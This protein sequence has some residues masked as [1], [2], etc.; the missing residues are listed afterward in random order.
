TPVTT[1]V[2]ANDTFEG[3]PVVTAVTQGTNGTVSI[4]ADN[5]ITYT[6]DVDFNGTDS[7]SYTVTSGGV[8]ETATVNVAVAPVVDI[9]DDIVTTDEDTAVTTDVLSND[10]FEGAPVVTA[11]TQAANGTVTINADNT[12]TYTPNHNYFGTDSYT[13]TVTSGGVTE[14]AVV[15]VTVNYVSDAVADEISTDEDTAVTTD[16]LANDTFEGAAAVTSV[17]QGANGAV[18]INAD[19]MVTYTPDADF[20]G[21]DSYS[22]TVTSGGVTETTTVSVTVN[23]V[24]DITDDSASTDEDTS[25]T[26]A[27]LSND[28]FEGTATV[29]AVTQGANGSVT[30]NADSTVTYTPDADFNGTDSYS[31]TVTSGGVTETATV[32]VTIN[33]VAD[34]A[35]DSATTVEDTTVTTD[36][37]AN[38]GFTGTPVV[39][40]VTQGANGTVTIN[41]DNTVSYTPNPDYYGSDSYSYTVT[42]GGVTETISVDVS[43]QPVADIVQDVVT[44]AEDKSVVSQLLGND[45]FA[46]SATVTSVTQGMNGTVHVN[47]DN[48][49]T[50]T[51]HPDFNGADQYSYTVTSGGFMETAT[52]DVTVT[53]VKDIMADA[54]VIDESSVITMNLLEND[55]F[56]GSPVIL[57][58]TQ[59]LNGSVVVN[60]DGTVTYTP[61]VGFIDTDTYSYTVSSG[62][63]LETAVVTVSVVPAANTSSP[64][65]P[66]VIEDEGLPVDGP[67]GIDIPVADKLELPV[68]E[69]IP[70][71]LSG[72]GDSLDNI[73]DG[74][75]SAADDD[76]I[77]LDENNEVVS[78]LK[79]RNNSGYIYFDADFYKQAHLLKSSGADYRVIDADELTGSGSFEFGKEELRQF[80]GEDGFTLALAEMDKAFDLEA[81]DKTIR[82]NLVTVSMTTLTVGLVSYLL[83]AGSLVASL[84]SSFPLWRRIDPI[85]VFARKKKKQAGKET[86]AE[87]NST[88]DQ[89]FDGRDE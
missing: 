20:N 17:T 60:A 75:I 45:Q 25:V 68:E 11:V 35:A 72:L 13:Y 28:S 51:P 62:G 3:T 10:H 32:S 49:V 65:E 74:L 18:T 40:S 86:S 54:M 38:D 89:L 22:Y 73:L 46:G 47:A 7:Y 34:I 61:N 31:Y 57:S 21:S 50:Y 85:V 2:L 39:S 8:T 69:D 79:K 87:A 33:A 9:N 70:G 12:V 42:S 24:A 80:T 43:I 1:S 67:G 26:T 82:S 4:N 19:N 66:G 16:V 23:P 29:T 78:S 64:D 52:V 37:L 88:T 81:E 84:M 76:I 77:Y 44:T 59:G 30:I 41:A 6:P 63:V 55:R 36:V 48:T 56:E 14:T 53:P 58:V 83:R 27:V 5:T 15:S 71:D